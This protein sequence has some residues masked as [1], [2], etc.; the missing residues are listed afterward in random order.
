MNI[1]TKPHLQDL[2]DHMRNEHGLILLQS[3]MQEI[4]A[5]CNTDLNAENE[6]LRYALQSMFELVDVAHSD[7]QE[8]RNKAF[9][10]AKQL[11]KNR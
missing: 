3:E 5:I 11:I 2:F 1:E 7:S 4:V 6:E 8:V 10:K 9:E